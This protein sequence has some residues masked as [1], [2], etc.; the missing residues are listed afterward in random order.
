M[1]KL[2]FLFLFLSLSVATYGCTAKS[3]TNDR[4]YQLADD[5]AQ[6][7]AKLDGCIK[8]E[9]PPPGF[10]G[11]ELIDYCT[12]RTPRLAKALDGYVVKVEHNSN[13]AILLVC[14]PD[15]SKALLEDTA[16]T[17]HF[18]HHHWQ[19]SVP[20]GFTLKLPEACDK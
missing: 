11:K 4:Y 1:N 3:T 12:S 18:D 13:N 15:G 14:S 8:Y 20:C 2:I 16:C 10:S 6:I 9:N 19:N 17:K 5:V 7:A